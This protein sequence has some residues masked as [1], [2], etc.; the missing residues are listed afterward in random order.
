M[1]VGDLLKKANQLKREDKWDEAIKLYYKIIEVAPH[2]LWTYLSLG[3]TLIKQGKFDEAIACYSESLKINPN[4]AWSF[5]SLG[6]V[7][8]QQGNF[9]EAIGCLQKA[10]Q[11]K[12]DCYKFYNSLGW[13]FT[14]KRKFNEAITNYN[15]AIKLNPKNIH[16]YLG[17]CLSYIAQGDL[18]YGE[19]YLRKTLEIDP[20][21]NNAKRYNSFFQVVSRLSEHSGVNL[22]TIKIKEINNTNENQIIK[23]LLKMVHNYEENSSSQAELM[24]PQLGQF[25]YSIA[26]AILPGI[27]YLQVLRQLHLF[28]KPINYIEIGVDKGESLK[29]AHLST[30]SIGIDPEPQLQYELPSNS[31]IFAISSDEFFQNYNL[32]KELE[33]QRVNFAF[34]DGL[35]LFEQA[36]K[37]FCNLEKYSQKNTVICFHDT[38]PLDEITSRRNRV[39]RFWSGDVW[40]I[41]PILK[42]YRPDLKIFTVATKPT[43][44]TIVTNLDPH[45]TILSENRDTI[46]DEFKNKRWIDNL[47]LRSAMLSVV[48][49]DWQVIKGELQ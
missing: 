42:Q 19:N 32:L 47:K 5:Y 7:F 48:S 39:T 16:S 20:E 9:K 33:G 25:H 4:S 1:S 40:K 18:D 37:D 49:N 10:I 41:V 6:E 26:E 31:K 29:L 27:E 44:L 43:G 2:L 38:L 8:A 15:K 30:F 3:D 23:K 45:S 28:L 12:P 36:I 35:H 22:N 34:I 24:A 17:C 14:Q 21:N 46:V 11:V 13:A